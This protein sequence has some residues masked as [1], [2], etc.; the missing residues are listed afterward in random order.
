MACDTNS[1]RG[2]L[3]WKPPR[4]KHGVVVIFLKKIPQAE[5]SY[6]RYMYCWLTTCLLV[7]VCKVP[8]IAMKLN[9]ICTLS[10]F[11]LLLI[12]RVMN[13]AEVEILPEV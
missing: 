9:H 11:D 8:L 10:M 7:L 5:K 4:E 3:Y 12:Y 1:I 2:G 6:V 13:T